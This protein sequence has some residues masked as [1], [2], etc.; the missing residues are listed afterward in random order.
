MFP[1]ANSLQVL[2]EPF[3]GSLEAAFKASLHLRVADITAGLPQEV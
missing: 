2:D 3:D 1:D